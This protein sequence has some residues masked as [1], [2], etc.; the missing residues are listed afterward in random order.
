[1]RTEHPQTRKSNYSVTVT[2]VLV[3]KSHVSVNM[4]GVMHYSVIAQ[5]LTDGYSAVC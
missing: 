5:K 3:F 1:M 4:P 2:K